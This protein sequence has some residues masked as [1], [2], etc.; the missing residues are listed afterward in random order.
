MGSQGG[1]LFGFV[2]A[3]KGGARVV[4]YF[5]MLCGMA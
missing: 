4:V 1:L 5:G 2:A 3:E